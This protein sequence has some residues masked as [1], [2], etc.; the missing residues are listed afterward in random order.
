MTFTNLFIKANKNLLRNKLRNTLSILAVI[1]SSA[2][3]VLIIYAATG[4]EKYTQD[5]FDLHRSGANLLFI[6]KFES[7]EV[8]VNFDNGVLIYQS[9]SENENQ[10]NSKNQTLFSNEVD[11][12]K[13]RSI[14]NVK[15]VTPNRGVNIE[16]V[17]R[18][19]QS[20]KYNVGIRNRSISTSP[21]IISGSDLEATDL[22][23]I[24]IPDNLSKVLGF[25]NPE[26]ALGKD[27]EI[28]FIDQSK[29]ESLLN[30]HANESK[31]DSSY[32][33]YLQKSL[34][35]KTYKIKGI[36][37]G[38]SGSP[39]FVSESEEKQLYDELYKET[40]DYQKYY[41]ISVEIKDGLTNEEIQEIKS[42]LRKLDYKFP[43]SNYEIIELLNG[44]RVVQYIAMGL[45]S[46][47]LIAAFFGVI[48]T[49][50][51]S[52][53]ERVKEIG[54][55]RA[56]GMSKLSIFAMFS[57]EAT[58][59]GFWGSILGFV[60]A[61]SGSIAGNYVIRSQD[62]LSNGGKTDILLYSP[63]TWLVV[64]GITLLTFVAGVIP[65]IKASRQD[66]IE[67]LRYE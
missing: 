59:L 54:L 19:K 20:K 13:V 35:T 37:S 42:Q 9:V 14:P 40:K 7:P 38:Y 60:I 64:L 33:K 62:L 27:I 23:L 31:G 30:Y 3:F 45:A 25:A 52:V 67:S 10:N 8:K 17:Q 48:N 55:M 22:D 5:S 18:D 2:V 58:L 63:S 66:P 24:I 39:M 1:I 46:V 36:T 57:M 4:L 56:L 28:T 44:I 34:V 43:D 47:G 50:M 61:H 26:N 15:K 51:M 49:Q 6:T 12:N 11:I 65:S 53:L 41:E 29:M 32:E 21:P 16:Y